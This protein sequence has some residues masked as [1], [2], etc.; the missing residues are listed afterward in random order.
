M[1]PASSTKPEV[2]KLYFEQ[3]PPPSHLRLPVFHTPLVHV[4][5]CIL[6]YTFTNVLHVTLH[7]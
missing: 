4:Y 2:L 3:Q 5:V 7:V 1:Q 6:Y